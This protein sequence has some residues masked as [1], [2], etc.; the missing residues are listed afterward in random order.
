MRR[1]LLTDRWDTHQSCDLEFAGRSAEGEK[2]VDVLRS[3]AS[4]LRL[5]A[6]IDLNEEQRFVPSS[7]K[8]ACEGLGQFRPIKGFYHVEKRHRVPNLIG[9]Q[10]SNKM[11]SNA[12]EFPAEGRPLALSLLHAIFAED[13]LSSHQD[14]AYG[15]DTLPLADADQGHC[16]G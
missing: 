11:Q 9:L 1:D 13:P 2:S 3:N 6:G 4:L 8:F 7:L 5:P 15:V 14:R 16:I 12:F 10:R